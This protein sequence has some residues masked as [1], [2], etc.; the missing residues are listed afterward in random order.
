MRKPEKL[1]A[2]LMFDVP[3]PVAVQGVNERYVTQ[4]I[5]DKANAEAMFTC[6]AYTMKIETWQSGAP[7]KE[8][9]TGGNRRFFLSAKDA[10]EDAFN[11]NIADLS[12]QIAQK[13][14]RFKL[15]IDGFP[16]P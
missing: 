5:F 15:S 12:G 6:N 3:A 14:K 7:F 4:S 10:A 2:P 9:Y 8:N 1:L 11:Q 16:R 13:I